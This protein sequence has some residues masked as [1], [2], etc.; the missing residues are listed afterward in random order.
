MVVLKPSGE[1]IVGNAVEEIRRLGPACFRNWQE[2]AELVDRNFLLAEDFDERSKRSLTD[3]LRRLK[4]KLDKKAAA[5]NKDGE[6]E[7]GEVSP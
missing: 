1:V 4:Y 7:E 3:P 5:K 2:A 6:E